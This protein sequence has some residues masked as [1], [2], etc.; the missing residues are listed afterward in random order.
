MQLATL[1]EA[2]SI[3]EEAAQVLAP[4]VREFVKMRLKRIRSK[5]GDLRTTLVSRYLAKELKY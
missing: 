5:K 1:L 4:E 3:E 2:N